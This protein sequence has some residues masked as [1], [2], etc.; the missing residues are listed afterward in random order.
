[1]NADYRGPKELEAR[2]IDWPT[3]N[4]EPRPIFDLVTLDPWQE[5]PGLWRED[6]PRW[7]LRLW[8]NTVLADVQ[9]DP[10]GR[11]RD[12]DLH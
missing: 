11:Q 10:H 2:V 6:A 12:S 7:V 3:Q 1:M 5:Q 8:T 4:P 9:K